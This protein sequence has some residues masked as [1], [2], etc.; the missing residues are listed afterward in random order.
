MKVREQ[1][2]I[3]QD[4]IEAKSTDN[5]YWRTVLDFWVDVELKEVSDLSYK[6]QAWLDK[7]EKA[8]RLDRG[9]K[10]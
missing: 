9:E 6:Q 8:L 7:I 4:E 1:Y 3:T 5:D 2:D 10:F